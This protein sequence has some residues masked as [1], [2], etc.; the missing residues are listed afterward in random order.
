M[1]RNTLTIIAAL[2]LAAFPGMAPADPAAATPLFNGKDLT[3]WKVPEGNVWWTATDGVLA[4]NNDPAK[5]GSMLYTA[6]E[7]GDFE[8]EAEAKWTGEIDSGFM[9]RKK[10][11]DEKIPGDLQMQIGVSRSLKKDMT[12]SF[13]IGKYPEE[14][15]AKDGL[16][17]LKP[18]D[19]NAFRIVAKG[20][21]GFVESRKGLPDRLASLGEKLGPAA[22]LHHAA[23][24]I[25]PLETFE[26]HGVRRQPALGDRRSVDPPEVAAGEIAIAETDLKAF[27]AGAG[28]GRRDRLLGMD[29]AQDLRA[30]GE[31]EL[32]QILLPEEPRALP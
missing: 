32:R 11:V 29:L 14:G 26:Q 9:F 19:W 18:D 25:A 20:D 1:N 15:Q 22:Q 6:E 17:L 12:G 8:L 28:G 13:Y 30:V 10:S 16:K 2:G 7:Y 5:K 4:G 3:G 23:V 24:E 31:R 27:S 21:L